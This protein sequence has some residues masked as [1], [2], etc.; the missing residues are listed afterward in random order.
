MTF[1]LEEMTM[2]DEAIVYSKTNKDL[3]CK[4]GWAAR[5]STPGRLES[6]AIDHERALSLLRLRQPDPREPRTRFLLSIEGELVVFGIDRD[7]S[8]QVT[9]SI[10]HLPPKLAV[11]EPELQALFAQA[12]EA[13]ADIFVLI[14]GFVPVSVSFASQKDAQ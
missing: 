5:S 12:F 10:L 6:W 11:R 3:I 8:P 2:D 4:F 9:A 7:L 1:R 13:G 14:V